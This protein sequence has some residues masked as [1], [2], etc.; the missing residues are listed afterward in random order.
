MYQESIYQFLSQKINDRKIPFNEEECI[1]FLMRV[2]SNFDVI[3][4]LYLSLYHNHPKRGDC[5]EALTE[6]LIEGFQKRSQ[7]LRQ[8]DIQ[9]KGVTPW[10]TRSDLV[11]MSLYVDRFCMN[12][13]DLRQKLEYL[14]DLGVN[15]VHLMPLMQSP[16]EASDGGYAVS[17]FRKVESRFGT[18]EQLEALI[19]EMHSK[20]MYLMLD[21]VLNHTSDQHEWARRA[22]AGEQQ[23]V[24]YFYMYDNRE[25][26]NDF[27]KTMPDIFPDSSPGSFTFDA[28]SGKWVMSVF[29][30]YQWDL[31]FTNPE[32]FV[33][34]MEHI[35]FYANLG[36]DVL[37]ID[38]PAFI[39]KK[40]GTTCQNLPE[41]H[42]ILQLIKH[43][44]QS[45]AP[46]LAL[47]GEAIVAPAEILK[48]FGTGSF[49]GRECDLAY[50]AT[51]MA[52]Q[53]DA[54][55]TGDVRVMMAAQKELLKKPFGT[56]WI[57]YTRCH[58]DIGLGYDDTMIQEAGFQ[59]ARHREFLKEY[60]SGKFPGSPARG[61]LFGVNPKTNDARIS[62]TLA[63]LCGL[64]FALEKN[65]PEEVDLSINKII[66]MQAQSLFI[67]GIP[68]LFYGDECG[69]LN[70]YSYQK[71]PAKNYDNRWMHRPE[72]NWEKNQIRK[73]K[74]SI[75]HR[76]FTQTQKLIRIRKANSIFSDTS[77]LAWLPCHNIHVAGFKRYDASESIICLF[78][79]SANKT[80][81]TWFVLKDAG[82]P[83]QTKIRD[84]WSGLETEVGKDDQHLVLNPYQFIIFVKI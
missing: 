67:G 31:N 79:F 50:N 27:E 57:T 63:S 32:V 49:V 34:M 60:Y 14:L 48:Y 65:R 47:L 76:I 33:R 19:G 40:I 74:G 66:L 78:N 36:V 46:G 84:V 58:D 82:W 28:Q 83:E 72:I 71:D 35:L 56:T 53:W 20:G 45:V 7:A 61:A 5:F 42:T 70:A 22:S 39:W 16:Q 64:E 37:R 8:L 23:F 43:C 75:E 9:K 55:A 2:S 25:I 24:E 41:A 12:L 77:N 6:I 10:F 30:S 11:G 1:S 81:L 21:I 80:G 3:H 73:K 13:S 15:F 17:D 69:Y 4:Q 44:V 52:L 62:G 26:P 59:P 29:N 54:L 68:V 51:Q 38:A 18:I